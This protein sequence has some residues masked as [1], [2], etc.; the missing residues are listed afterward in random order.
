MAGNQREELI[1]NVHSRFKFYEQR[2]NSIIGEIMSGERA[3]LP[4]WSDDEEEGS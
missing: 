1:E 3:E 4:E 2:K